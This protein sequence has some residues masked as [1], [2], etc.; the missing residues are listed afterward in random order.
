MWYSS[1]KTTGVYILNSP[2]NREYAPGGDMILTPI[3]RAKKETAEN[4]NFQKKFDSVTDENIKDMTLNN[5]REF[6]EEDFSNMLWKDL[7]SLTMQDFLDKIIWKIPLNFLYKLADINEK[8][9]SD[10]WYESHEIINNGLVVKEIERIPSINIDNF[11]NIFCQLTSEEISNLLEKDFHKYKR[12]L[13]WESIPMDILELIAYKNESLLNAIW[14][15][16]NKKWQIFK[17]GKS[18]YK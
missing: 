15:I 17:K 13:N 2:K 5:F 4:Q 9:L 1:N 7:S 18:K 14:F 16:Q 10:L 12:I 11:I 6:F 3:R 8:L